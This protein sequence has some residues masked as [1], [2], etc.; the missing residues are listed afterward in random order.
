MLY[1]YARFSGYDLGFLRIGGTGLGNL[2]FPWARSIVAAK[3]YNLIPVGPTWHQL[4]I[5]PFIRNEKDK[6][7]YYGLFNADSE[8]VNGWK[9]I[10]LLSRFLPAVNEEDLYAGS[11]NDDSGDRVVIFEGM[12]GYF[13]EILTHHE[14]VRQELL[15]IT[16]EKHKKGL[17][18]DFRQSI[19]VHVRLTDFILCTKEKTPGS[20]V[21]NMLIP[22]SWYV[23]V[24][25]RIRSLAGADIPIYVFSDGTDEELAGL[26][27]LPNSQRLFF[28]SSIADLIA[29]SRAQILVASG[30][31]FSMWASYLG[32]MPVIWQRGRL[33][34]K[35]YYENEFI[36]IQCDEGAA[37]PAEFCALMKDNFKGYTDSVV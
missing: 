4:K 20:D 10:F 32:R 13:Q 27:R 28:G 25:T 36:E 24:A 2:L 3:K 19:S 30:S 31:T 5:G 29:L 18:F 6:R 1:S 17:A 9:K 12:E 23:D 14:Y 37:F 8:H 35:L 26:L 21:S 22:I 34:Q 15:K 11:L 7:L 33:M 16:K